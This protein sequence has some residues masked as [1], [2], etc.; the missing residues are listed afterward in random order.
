MRLQTS[1][2]IK[3]EVC[4]GPHT[5][6]IIFTHQ[7]FSAIFRHHPVQKLFFTSLCKLWV[8]DIQRRMQ[9]SQHPRDVD[10]DPLPSPSLFDS[11]LWAHSQAQRTSNSNSAQIQSFFGVRAAFLIQGSRRTGHDSPLDD[12]GRSDWKSREL[13]LKMGDEHPEAGTHDSCN[14]GIPTS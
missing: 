2:Y 14:Q 11:N 7:F 1:K 12:S 4:Q 8:N 10:A 6:L 9:S 13:R 3:C 5:S